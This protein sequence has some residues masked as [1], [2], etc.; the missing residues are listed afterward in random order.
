VFPWNAI[1]RVP[2]ADA[3]TRAA[4][5]V[6]ADRTPFAVKLNRVVND[7][8]QHLFETPRIG[9]DCYT[10][11]DFVKELDLTRGGD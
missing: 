11:R 10:G 5:M 6:N 9:K 2:D 1:A 4:L 7:I 8:R 3:I